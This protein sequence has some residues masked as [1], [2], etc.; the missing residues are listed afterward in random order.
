MRSPALRRTCV[1]VF[2]PMVMLQVTDNEAIRPIAR[3]VQ[4]RL[5]LA[6][7]AV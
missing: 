2:D 4:E 6:F 5:Q 7:A 1:S 3:E